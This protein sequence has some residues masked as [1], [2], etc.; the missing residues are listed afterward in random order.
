MDRYRARGYVAHS[1]KI[2]GDVAR[3]IARIRDVEATRR[4]ARSSFTT[5][6]AAGPGAGASGHAGLT[7]EPQR[8]LRAALRNA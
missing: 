8:H 3:D 4:P 6:T 5:S 1:V 7:E 2:G